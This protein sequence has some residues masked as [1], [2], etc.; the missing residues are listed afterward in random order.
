MTRKQR[1]AAFIVV[2]LG[3]LG[4]AVGLVLYA[5]SDS[6]VY[7][8]SPSDVVERGVEPGERI[9]L[10]GL[11]EQDSLQD[12]GDATVRF[13]VTDFVETFTVTADA[14]EDEYRAKNNRQEITVVFSDAADLSV[15]ASLLSTGINNNGEGTAEVAVTVRNLSTIAGAVA[16]NVALTVNPPVGTSLTSSSVPCDN[17]CNL[18][19]L[20]PGQSSDVT[21]TFISGTPQNGTLSLAVDTTDDE[22]P[23]ANN[24]TG[25]ALSYS[26]IRTTSPSS[27]EGGGG[28]GGGAL[29]TL[30]ALIALAGLRRRH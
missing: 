5:M 15:D 25:V 6:I 8:Y 10:G 28:G 18:G 24:S 27:N 1:R 22:F 26:N 17:A 30:L 3:I 29:G 13:N 23:N 4:L 21:L 2:A 14:A 11:V 16:G 19:E 20:A 9:R 7:F 12:L